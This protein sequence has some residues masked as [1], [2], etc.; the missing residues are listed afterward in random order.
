MRK[1]RLSAKRL[2]SAGLMR[3]HVTFNN[4]VAVIRS[5]IF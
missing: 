5:G 3:S 1:A 2:E 4:A